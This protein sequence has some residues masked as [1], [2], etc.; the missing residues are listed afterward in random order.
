MV[1]DEFAGLKRM[2]V[3]ENAVAQIAGYGVKLFFVLQS[4]EQIKAVYK[5]N[6]ET[7]LANAGLKVFFNLED[8]F[9]REYVSK[10]IGETEQIREVRS[11][12]DSISE[13]ESISRSTSRSTSTGVSDTDGTSSSDSTGRSWGVNSSKGRSF[14]WS[15]GRNWAYGGFL[16]GKDWKGG[17]EGKGDGRSYTDG[18]SKG[19]TDGHSDG[20]SQSRSRSRSE[21]T[22]ETEGT[23]YSKSQSR[24]A[25]TSETIQKRALITPDEIGQVFARIDDRAHPAYPGLALVVISGARPMAVRRVNYYEDFRFMGLFDPPPDYPY[26]APKEL[27]VEGRALGFPVAAFGLHLGKWSITPGQIAA[28]GDEGVLVVTAKGEAAAPIRI[29]RDGMITA[30]G[31]GAGGDVPDGPLFSLL[32]YDDGTAAG[33][34]FA[35]LRRFCEQVKSLIAR[36][37]RENQEKGNRRLAAAVVLGVVL[38]IVVV[39]AGIANV[40]KRSA[41]ERAADKARTDKNAAAQPSAQSTAPDPTPADASGAMMV[42]KIDVSHFAGLT[43]GDTPDRVAAIY[44]LP[45]G[46]FTKD[47]EEVV[48]NMFANFENG[49]LIGVYIHGENAKEEA[50][51]HVG[52]D[53]LLALFGRSQADVVALLG[54]PNGRET[55]KDGGTALVWSFSTPGRPKRKSTAWISISQALVLRFSDDSGCYEEAILW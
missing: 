6:W 41:S 37:D 7:F 26:V 3:I 49:A 45:E 54:P 50:E 8:H 11:A 5:D 32:Y 21:S 40:A 17:N 1:L 24:T 42:G 18:T 34:P 39:V 20:I 12:S 27:T 51:A 25:G 19:W 22:S 46:S 30:V 23:S 55:P 4:L 9:S 31:G 43:P 52:M 2:E 14:N 28:S 15:S 48:K 33:D 16:G 35:D 53:P 36:Q 13:S 29:P 38:A 10:L 47:R 44:G